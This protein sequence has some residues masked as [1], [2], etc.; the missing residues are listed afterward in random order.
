M[1]DRQP[2]AARIP[3]GL[4]GAGADLWRQVARGYQLRPDELRLLEDA[5]R[6]VSMID[7]LRDSLEGQPLV[8]PGVKGQDRISPLVVEMRQQR[9][10]L[11]GLLRQL[12]LP[13]DAA[14]GGSAGMPNSVK[15]RS[16][17]N[18]RWGRPSSGAAR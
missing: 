8:V 6:T 13:D 18:A 17:A 14:D 9:V 2:R 7:H 11:S 10:V 12:G 1:T 3:A 16:A 5:C 15:A 4:T